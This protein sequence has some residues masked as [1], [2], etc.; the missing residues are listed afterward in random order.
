MLWPDSKL[1]LPKFGEFRHGLL[2]TIT[3]EEDQFLKAVSK[4]V[5]KSAAKDAFIFVHGYNVTFEDAARRTGQ[6]AFDLRFIGAPILYH[7]CPRQDRP[8]AWSAENTRLWRIPAS[9]LG[10]GLRF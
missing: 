5:D 6:F 1:P 4:S 2:E 8:V 7:Y 3:L 10:E 9:Y